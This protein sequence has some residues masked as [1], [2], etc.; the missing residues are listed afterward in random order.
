M[1]T[2][3]FAYRAPRNYNPGSADV[4]AE[5]QAWFESLGGQLAD[6][7]N[8]VFVRRT[9]GNCGSDTDLGGYSLVTADSLEAA[10]AAASGCPLLNSGGGVEVGEL[11]LLNPVG[12]AT[13]AEDHARSTA[14]S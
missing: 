2:F 11:T 4:A 12:L 9:L 6:A 13:T 3:V 1:P 10:V 7:G 8:P 14:V 5:W